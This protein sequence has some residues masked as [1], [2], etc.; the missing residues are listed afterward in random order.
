[1]LLDYKASRERLARKANKGLLVLLVTPADLA[2]L[3]SLVLLD[4][5]DRREMLDNLV[6][7]AILDRLAVEVRGA[8]PD[9]VD[10]LAVLV[11]VV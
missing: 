4:V 5:M 9:A 7:L 2:L 11:S 10:H 1:M 3:V 8:T 6:L